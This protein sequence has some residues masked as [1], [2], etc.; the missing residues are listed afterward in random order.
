MDMQIA[1][2]MK[3]FESR[4]GPFRIECAVDRAHG[5]GIGTLHTDLQT[6]FSLGNSGE[7]GK[8]FLVEQC[9]G[10][11]EM[12][13]L[14]ISIRR[15]R[16]P[17][18]LCAFTVKIK[19]AVHE[20]DGTD[21][22]EFFKFQKIVQGFFRGLCA[23]SL[24]AR[25]KTVCARKRTAS[26]GFVIHK[27]A[28]RFTD[29]VVIDAAFRKIA[30]RRCHHDAVILHFTVCKIGKKLRKCILTLTRDDEIDV[31]VRR[32]EAF[33]GKRDLRTAENDRRVRQERF[34]LSGEIKHLRN[35]PDICG[36]PVHVRILGNERF[37]DAKSGILQIF[38]NQNDVLACIAKRNADGTHGKI[39]M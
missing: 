39:R 33:V 23:D 8:G 10:N 35:I 19:R 29:L 7:N 36:K 17:D 5:L 21:T 34:Q 15:K 37:Q 13:F 32:K 24:R 1:V 26:H 2:F 4:N 31:R 27:S 30:V 18:G 28:R 11:L 12:I 9:R 22:V 14:G 3:F 6:E 25:G 38:F 20:L 16:T